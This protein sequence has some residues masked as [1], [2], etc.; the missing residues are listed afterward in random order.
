MASTAF[1]AAGRSGSGTPASSGGRAAAA[2]AAA[3]AASDPMKRLILGG[4]SAQLNLAAV[5]AR[6]EDLKRSLDQ[7]AF[8]LE[9]YADRVQW[10]DA[11][12]KFGVVNVQMHRLSQE[13]RPL[14]H[15]YA[16][17]P[18]AVNAANA[19][20]LPIMLSTM[21]LPEMEAEEKGLLA[22][23]AASMDAMSDADLHAALAAREEQLNGLVEHLTIVQHAGSASAGILD[24][25]GPRLASMAKE[26]HAAATAPAA[27]PPQA[28]HAASTQGV[29]PQRAPEVDRLFAAVTKGA[30]LT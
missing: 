5:K 30:G 12:D 16:V 20:I 15:Y 27:Q 22:D 19:P 26:L 17:H 25:K 2:Q 9:H 8:A 14:L 21:A 10:R 4:G 23:Q 24:P 13:L 1:S 11:L 7:I 28:S 29:R 18:K 3:A 6:A